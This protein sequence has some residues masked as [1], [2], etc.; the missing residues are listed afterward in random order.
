MTPE[1]AKRIWISP[2]G[3]K[4]NPR[5]HKGYFHATVGTIGP[6]SLQ[7]WNAADLT[8]LGWTSEAPPTPP[9]PTPPSLAD[10]K[11]DYLTRVDAD[12]E[13]ERLLYI[14]PG[15]GQ[16]MTY[17]EKLEQAKAV[18][19]LGQ[20]A[21]DALT[22]ADAKTQYPILEAGVGIHAD[23][24]WEHA[25]LVIARYEAWNDLAGVIETQRETAK[26]SISDASDQA[27]V[28]AAYE[29]ITWPSQQ[30]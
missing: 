7:G 16:A 10:V 6:R 24:L 9:A 28:L 17:L 11:A 27:A 12:A 22:T 20:S 3:D 23:S 25:Q 14:T 8:A 30:T 4:L 18:D 15:D 13:T 2:S 5:R 21:A 1:E 26:K 19:A 29:A